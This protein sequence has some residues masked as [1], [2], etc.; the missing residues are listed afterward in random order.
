PERLTDWRGHPWTKGSR[1]YAAHPNSRFTV[2][3]ANNPALSRFA[4]DPKGVPISAIPFGG[5]RSTTVPLVLQVFN[6][7]HGVY[8]GPTS[9]AG[10]IETPV[11][12][13]PR[14]GDLDL[15][16]LDLGPE[17]LGAALRVDP[18][19]WVAELGTHA[20]WFTKLG[21]TVPGVLELQRKLLLASVGI[22][23][24]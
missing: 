18:A 21:G 5:R 19:E 7:T 3:M 11:G 13:T 2:P 17:R 14:A 6:W 24:S 10:A 8:L 23:G 22:A 15:T 16:G 20:D 12:W 4:E 1:E 9:G